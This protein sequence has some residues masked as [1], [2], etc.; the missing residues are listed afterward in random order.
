MADIATLG[1]A[2]DLQISQL[3]H[4]SNNLAN[5]STPGFKAVHLLMLK[6]LEEV[7][8]TEE[9]PEIPSELVV[10]FSQGIPQ[11]TS[12]I[13]DVTIQGDGFFVIQTDQGL[14]YTKN[15][16][17]TVNS[18]NQIVAQDGSLVMGTS[19]PITLI[20]GQ[21]NI[22]QDGS[23]S[24]DGNEIGKLKIVDFTNR[25]ALVKASG[26]LYYD[27][28]QAGLKAVEKPNIQSGFLELS[29]VNVVRE[30]ADMITVNRLFETYQKLIQAIQDQDKLAI[31]RLGKL[32]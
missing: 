17:F 6:D 4:I 9:E 7:A 10:D 27:E 5:A 16:T 32:I 8:V 11:K 14:A 20:D 2:M 3:E 1:A 23:I 29:N 28:G 21:I 30:M 24:V 31:N 18:S 26:S 12:N 22:A 25:Q 13:L 15:G 19:G